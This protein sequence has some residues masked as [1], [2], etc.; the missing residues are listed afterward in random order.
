VNTIGVVQVNVQ[1]P[2]YES[3]YPA[4]G[5][6]LTR[7]YIPAG[8]QHMTGNEAL[9]YARSRHRSTDFDRGRR[10][11]R[12]LVS[13]KEQMSVQAV[14]ANLDRLLDDVASNVKTDIPTGELPKLLALADGV[15]TRNI[16]SYVFSPQFY[17]TEYLS[18]PRGY[19][20]T[21]NVP[22]I[23]RAVNEAFSVS[24]EVAERRDRLGTEAATVWVYNASGRTGLSA[25]AAEYLAYNGLNASAPTR[26]SNEQ[27]AATRIEVYNG[28][29]ADMPATIAYLERLYD[30]TVVPVADPG[31]TVDIVIRL[32]RDAPDREVEAVG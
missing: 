25:R 16:R 14:L 28:A 12:V 30:T 19:I 24:P 29:E 2:V 21:P 31:V 23:R 27:L 32:G 4:G 10:Q 6:N 1:M 8:P 15:D 7:L 5:G 13:L 22:R 17:A 18:S 20:I 3:L 11:Q 26:G 9:R